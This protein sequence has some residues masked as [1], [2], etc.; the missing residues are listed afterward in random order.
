M[1]L[2][3]KSA[4]LWDGTG[5][6]VQ[7]NMGIVMEN[8]KFTKIAPCAQ[9]IPQEGD[10]V[11]DVGYRFVMPGMIDSHVHVCSTGEPK[12]LTENEKAPDAYM[13]LVGAD[14][15]RRDLEAGFTTVR[16]MGTK[17]YMDMSIQKAWKEGR[18]K[19]ARIIT[20]GPCITMTGGHG[21]MGGL[22]SDGEDE[23]RKNA[24]LLLRNGVEVVKIMATGGVM[25]PGVEPGSPQLTEGEIRAAVEEAHK[26]GRKT[27]T[28]AQG[29]EGIKNAVRAGIDS[30]EHG[31]FLDEELLVMMKERNTALVPTLVAPW[32]INQGGV[33]AGIPAYAVEKS[34]RV[35]DSHMK[36][37]NM[38]VKAGLTIALGTDAGTPLNFHGDNALELQLMTEN[39]MTN[40]QALLAATKVGSQ[41]IDRANLLGT[42]EEGKIADLLVVDGNPLEDIQ[43]L[44]K[45]QA[46]QYVIQNGKVVHTR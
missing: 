21:W 25:T 36:S 39:G 10:T 1:A 16:N 6:A 9:V 27:A 20:C 19:G 7:Q 14:M 30:I 33:A 32:H 23:C 17:N 12:D 15:I 2:V 42:V 3:I 28:H 11:I 38:A 43:V 34:M 44:V 46:I 29:T 24:R 5:K 40:E 45:K 37:F 35:A 13:A 31:I 22:Q 41:V 4:N 18:I 26:A 8:G